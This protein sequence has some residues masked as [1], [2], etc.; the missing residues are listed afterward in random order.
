MKK[1]FNLIRSHRGDSKNDTT[2]TTNTNTIQIIK[3]NNFFRLLILDSKIN[4][5]ER[6][7]L[8]V[9]NKL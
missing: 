2:T 5:L 3:K 8:A 6:S 1:F 4:N 7:K 9:K